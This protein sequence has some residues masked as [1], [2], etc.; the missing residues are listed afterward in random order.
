LGVPPTHCISEYGM[1]E[2]AS[3]FY[4][5]TYY[6]HVNGIKRAPRKVAPPTVR[7]R[8]MD[9]VTGEDAAPG[10]PGLLAHCDLANLN[11]V[12]AI[13]TEDMGVAADDGDGITLLGRA[14]GAVLRGCSLTAEEMIAPAGT[15]SAAD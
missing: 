11:S 14:P 15:G 5:S 9:P 7:T 13:Q 2:M 8:V 6:D 1:S 4:D 10:Q 12:L 3:Q